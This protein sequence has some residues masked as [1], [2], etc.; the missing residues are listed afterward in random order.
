MVRH[1]DIEIISGSDPD[2]D[3]ESDYESDPEPKPK[4]EPKVKRGG[5]QRPKTVKKKATTKSMK[6]KVEREEDGFNPL[7]FGIL[8][9]M[10]GGGA[11]YYY[12]KNLETKPTV[13]PKQS[14]E[15]QRP[16]VMRTA[17][18][19]S[20]DTKQMRAQLG[21]LKKQLETF[22]TVSKTKET[23]PVEKPVE[24]P[25]EPTKPSSSILDDL[26][27]KEAL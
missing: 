20:S 19:V 17:N 22:K 7:K 13:L 4:P 24:K 5:A 12:Y 25:V 10:L 15:T 23:N 16:M 27:G 21:E 26:L 14:R 18:V 1:E 6:K 11:L 3:F 2:S 8:G 9:L